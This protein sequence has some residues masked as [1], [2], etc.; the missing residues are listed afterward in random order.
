ML[1]MQIP[2]S[3]RIIAAPKTG[4]RFGP[5]G[6]PGPTTPRS[7]GTPWTTMVAGSAA[8]RGVRYSRSPV[9]VSSASTAKSSVSMPSVGVSG[10]D[11]SKP[12]PA[13]P[14]VVAFGRNVTVSL[15]KA[16]PEIAYSAR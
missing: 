13:G 4:V 1:L 6:T 7:A 16:G 5:A 14:P 9:G 3:T 10:H 11:K 12:G 8:R 2:F 15:A